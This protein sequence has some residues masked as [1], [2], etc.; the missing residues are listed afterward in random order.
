[1]SG[2][3]SQ[4]AGSTFHTLQT[5]P[6]FNTASSLGM[7]LGVYGGSGVGSP[8]YSESTDYIDSSLSLTQVYQSRDGRD[9][10]SMGIMLDFASAGA[11]GIG[12]DECAQAVV[13]DETKEAG[14]VCE[15][16]GEEGESNA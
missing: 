13:G 9:N 15:I 5:L 11:S 7:A 6:S 4:H 2:T 16:P 14:G 10:D 3:I 1:V 8:G 12:E